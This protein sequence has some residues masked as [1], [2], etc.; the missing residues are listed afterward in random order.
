MSGGHLRPGPFR[1]SHDVVDRA[2]AWTILESR[3]SGTSGNG[4]KKPVIRRNPPLSSSSPISKPS[5]S[6]RLSRSSMTQPKR[7]MRWR[8]ST[9]LVNLNEALRWRNWNPPI[10]SESAA[11]PA[12]TLQGRRIDPVLR[13]AAH[14]QHCATANAAS[15]L[16]LASR[17]PSTLSEALRTPPECP[18]NVAT[19]WPP[20]VYHTR[21]LRSQLALATS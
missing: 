2:K 15:Q 13:P 10:S 6:G 18:G 19:N 14:Q 12:A 8:S 3:L 17:L 20:R 4:P 1:P 9:P 21:K 5:A 7:T 11:R 16:P